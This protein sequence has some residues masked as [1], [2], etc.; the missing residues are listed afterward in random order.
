MGGEAVAQLVRADRE[1]NA[2][3]FQ[4]LLE[5]LIH[6]LLRDAGA[7]RAEEQRAGSDRRGLAV[8]LDRCQR[9]PAHR[10]DALLGTF[11]HD[12]HSLTDEIQVLH[13]QRQQLGNPQAAGIE[14][15]ENRRIPQR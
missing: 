5:Q 14:K 11:S 3:A 1:R 10:D 7:P 6:R 9:R 12:S 4:I 8:A 15:L 13:I 2:A